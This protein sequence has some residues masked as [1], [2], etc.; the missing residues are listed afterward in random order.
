MEMERVVRHRVNFMM[1][2]SMMLRCLL[3][4]ASLRLAEKRTGG[5][6]CQQY[7][8][9]G[10]EQPATAAEIC[11][12]C[13][14]MHAFRLRRARPG[15]NAEGCFFGKLPVLGFFSDRERIPGSCGFGIPPVI[16]S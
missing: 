12:R 4:A 8:Q 14:C 1:T 5:R 16:S 10:R 3:E 15:V 2:S 13:C 9:S 11:S 6:Q 7:Q